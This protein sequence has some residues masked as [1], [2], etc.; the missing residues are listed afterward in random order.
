MSAAFDE[1][2]EIVKTL[3]EKCPWDRIQTHASMRRFLIEEAFEAAEAV[4][5]RDDDALRNELGD[6]LLHVCFHSIIADERGAFNIEGVIRAISNKLVSRHPH[7]FENVPVSGPIEVI[8]NWEAIKA[9]ESDGNKRLLDGVPRG[10]PALVRAH[11]IQDRVRSVGFEWEDASGVFNKIAEETEE[12]R[13][14]MDRI[15]KDGLER[16]L[17]DLLFSF[18]NLCRYLGVDPSSALNRTSDEFIRRFNIVEEKLV[19]RG[20]SLTA[21]SLD[22]ME[23]IWQGSK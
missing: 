4:D 21:A 22:E 10:L 19:A 23:E 3:R 5:A 2:L 12:V 7:V 14:V 6:I 1:F 17:G 9:K 13:S 8:E 11:R 18:V 15:D 20:R 16:E